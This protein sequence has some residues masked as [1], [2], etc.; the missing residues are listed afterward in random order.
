[1]GIC[2]D[3][4]DSIKDFT[5]MPIK[6][7]LTNEDINTLIKECTVLQQ[8]YQPQMEEDFID[9][10]VCSLRK[11]SI[12]FLQLK[13]PIH[14]ARAYPAMVD[15]KNA[16]ICEQQIAEHKESIAEFKTYLG[17]D[18]SLERRLLNQLS[19]HG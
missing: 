18:H 2:Q 10:L 3:T 1:M 13:C 17:I 7:Q 8:V 5:F 16:V 9:T 4:K 14:C 12:L 11:K 15:E 19:H 6:G